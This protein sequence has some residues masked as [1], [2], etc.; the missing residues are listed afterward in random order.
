MEILSQQG[1]RGQQRGE[2]ATELVQNGRQDRPVGPGRERPERASYTA[3]GGVQVADRG[4]VRRSA[5]L[6]MARGRKTSWIVILVGHRYPPVRF[7]AQPSRRACPGIG[8]GAL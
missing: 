1:R 6:Q 4:D 3:P 2:G 7:G 5:G 8:R